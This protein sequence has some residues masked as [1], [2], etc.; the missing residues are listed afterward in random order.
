MYYATAWQNRD[1]T[2]VDSVL[3]A[4]YQGTSTDPPLTLSFVKY[5]EIRALHY[6]A[7]DTDLTSVQVNL[8]PPSSWIR[9]SYSSDPPDWT[10]IL[11]PNAQIQLRYSTGVDVVV[12][13][14]TNKFK[15]KPTVVGSDTTWEIIRWEEFHNSP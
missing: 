11:V 13:N 15:L 10:V 3:A 8:G 9:D 1:S 5:D 6:M 14:A 7:L 2:R 12:N 4:D